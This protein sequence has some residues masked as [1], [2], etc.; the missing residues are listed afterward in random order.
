[1]SGSLPHGHGPALTGGVAL[2][3]AA[4]GQGQASEPPS[5]PRPPNVLLITVD[6]LRADRLGFYGY[7]PPTSPELDAFAAGA[8]VFDTAMAS[9]PWTLPA[10]ASVLTSEYTST[11]GCWKHSMV[12]DES[13]TTLPEIL[14]AAGYDTAGI[15]IQR[16]V[17][18]RYGLMQGIVHFDDSHTYTDPQPA[19]SITSQG[20]S[21]KAL[22]FLEQKAAA[23]ERGPWFLWLHYMDPHGLYVEHPGI[24]EAFVS[25]GEKPREQRQAELYDGE[26]RYTDGQI[27]RVLE[28]LERHG[29]GPETVVVFL[30]DHGEELQD[31]GRMG[32]GHTVFQELVRVPFVIRAPGCAPARVS[33]VVRQVDV[34]PTVLEL[35]RVP[36]PQGIAGRSLVPLLRGEAME[37][38]PALVELALGRGDTLDALRKGALKV[39]ATSKE[40]GFRALYD[41]SEDPLETR[42]LREERPEEFRLLREE[43]ERLRGIALERA[44]LFGTAREIA[45]TP[46]EAQDLHDLGYGGTG[47]DE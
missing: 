47:E 18:T 35:C 33:T 23:P 43:L 40:G 26:I 6:T 41:V 38:V 5:G 36:V 29:F 42:D 13:F 32:H 2:V 8:V 30:S 46:G 12:L 14:L 39:V 10:L 15:V 19:H 24:T 44:R 1:M 11:H 20:V 7:Q 17:T 28:G 27:G 31:H 4:C 9:A 25:A 16:F 22:R 45:F 21:D 37:E 34:L 3:L